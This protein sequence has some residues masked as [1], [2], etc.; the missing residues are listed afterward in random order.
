MTYTTEGEGSYLDRLWKF[1]HLVW[2][3]AS[4]DL[5]ARF[6]RSFFGVFWAMLQPLFLVSILTLVFSTFSND[7]WQEYFI[8]VFSGLILW[9]LISEGI[10]LGAS[11]IENAA[12]YIRQVRIPILIFPTRSVMHAIIITTTGFLSLLLFTLIVLP[13]SLDWKW[14]L[15]PFVFIQ[16]ALFVLPIAII[17]SFIALRFRDYHNFLALFLQGFWFFS[18]VF[19]MREVFDKP[20]LKQ[21]T[22]VNPVASYCDSLRAL[23]LEHSYPD[24]HDLW[25]P[26]IWIIVS[27]VA[28]IWL[29]RRE[30]S[31]AIWYL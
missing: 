12:G 21:F 18:P 5:R 1:R 6:R 29:L 17:S 25:M 26:L 22:E 7:P 31:K 23:L 24:A 16:V 4:V 10:T 15:L 30:E 2:H 3:L 19:V 14:L 9:G 11:S 8:Y 13:Q 20:G 27:W 28:A